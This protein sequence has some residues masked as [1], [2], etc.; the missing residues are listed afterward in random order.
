MRLSRAI[1]DMIPG[2]TGFTLMTFSSNWFFFSKKLLRFSSRAEVIIIQDWSCISVK[3]ETVLYQRILQ[4]FKMEIPSCKYHYLWKNISSLG[5]WAIY[6]MVD[7]KSDENWEFWNKWKI[8]YNFPTTGILAKNHFSEFCEFLL[9][10]SERVGIF[11]IFGKIGNF[12]HFSAKFPIFNIFEKIANFWLFCVSMG[13]D[14]SIPL[15][16]HNEIK[17]SIFKVGL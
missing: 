13:W 17:R 4:M 2:Y 16:S 3:M 5:T 15:T 12:W 7:Q 10:F 6:H 11:S 8:S 9:L 1:K 14:R